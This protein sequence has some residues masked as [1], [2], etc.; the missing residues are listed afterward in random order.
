MKIKNVLFIVL[1]LII[2]IGI[3]IDPAYPKLMQR[4]IDAASLYVALGCIISVIVANIVSGKTKIVLITGLCT[5][6]IIAIL[7]FAISDFN[8]AGWGSLISMIIVVYISIAF[9][10]KFRKSQEAKHEK[11]L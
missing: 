9:W 10:H 3:I 4:D 2:L 6:S 5:V 8:A 11:T 1:S 7:I